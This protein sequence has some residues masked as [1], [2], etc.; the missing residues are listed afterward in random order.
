MRTWLLTA[1]L[2]SAMALGACERG[3]DVQKMADGALQSVDLDDKVDAK[4]DKS[5]SVVRLTGTVDSADERSRANDVVT[6]A[7]RAHAQVA[8]E[9]VVR[10]L[11]AD[12]A[13][14]LDGGIE[15][16][17][18][19]L[20]DNAPDLKEGDVEFRVKNGVV[21]LTGTTASATQSKKVEELASSIPGVTQVVNSLA[22]DNA[23]A[24]RAARPR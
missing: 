3:P 12:T 9:V 18:K 14:D 7:I 10:G 22:V 15:E 20:M 21:T 11:Q 5:A 2:T 4:Y 16:R 8:N 19:T 6:A 23:D 13:D 24:P 1:A 17:F